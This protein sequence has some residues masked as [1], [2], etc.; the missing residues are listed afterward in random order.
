[1]LMRATPLR[2]LFFLRVPNALPTLFSGLRL[3]VVYAPFAVIVGEWV[4]SSRGL[5]YLMLLADGRGQTDLMFAA[6]FVLSGMS[7]LLFAVLERLAHSS[8]QR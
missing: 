8:L 1:M 4:G 5:G 7:L 3:A 6:V 2:Q